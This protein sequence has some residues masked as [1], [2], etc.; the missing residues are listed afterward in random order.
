MKK[1]LIIVLVCL[2]P[3]LL[4]AQSYL[5]NVGIGVTNPSFPLHIGGTLGAEILL[6][7]NNTRADRYRIMAASDE[8]G[9]TPGD[10]FAIYNV[11][12]YRYDLVLKNNGFLGIGTT[13]PQTK[14]DVA[15]N[16]RINS[17]SPSIVLQRN[18]DYGGYIQGVQTRLL[19]GTGTW[20]WGTQSGSV[21]YISKGEYSGPRYFSILSNGNVGIGTNNPGNYKLAVEGKIGAREIVVTS[22]GWSDFVF[23][24][25]YQL[26]SLASVAAY[27]ETNNHLPD[28]PSGAEIEQGGIAVS[29]M[30]AKQMQKIEELTLYV[31]ELEKENS[32]LKGSN[33]DILDRLAVIESKL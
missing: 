8:G 28:V 32:D 2:L 14:L 10:A 22:A 13:N 20:W 12:S 33:Q 25:D 1:I 4:S 5:E 11:D 27:I 30:L 19:D 26:R 29:E 21:W 9:Y 7:P 31:I 24:D 17:Y 15:G 16:M 18:A 23:A 6:D 3:S